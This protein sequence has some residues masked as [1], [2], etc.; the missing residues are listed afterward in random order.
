MKDQSYGAEDKRSSVQQI[1]VYMNRHS[2][3]KNWTHTPSTSGSY[4]RL[5]GR[6][7]DKLGMEVRFPIG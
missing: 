6:L 5:A 1:H 3:V 2:Y 4:S 7:V